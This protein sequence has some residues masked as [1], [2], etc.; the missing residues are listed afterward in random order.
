LEEQEIHYGANSYDE[1]I[2]RIYVKPIGR[3]TNEEKSCEEAQIK[4]E[5]VKREMKS[6]HS[7]LSKEEK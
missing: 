3:I 1:V 2:S 6:T 7:K 4:E 5:Q